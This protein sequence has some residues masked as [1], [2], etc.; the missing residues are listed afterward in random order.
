MQPT[1]TRPRPTF[2]FG[3]LATVLA[4]T[5]AAC[6]SSAPSD[7]FGGTTTLHLTG[8]VTGTFPPAANCVVGMSGANT[9][10]ISFKDTSGRISGTTTAVT[11]SMI[12]NV[13]VTGGSITFPVPTDT[14]S[15][16]LENTGEA[17]AYQ[18]A[19]GE[20]SLFKDSAGTLTVAS[21]GTSGSID[22]SL[23]PTSVH[24]NEANADVQISGS[25]SNCPQKPT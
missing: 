25:W 19:A 9:D 6:G 16:F 2:V 17:I 18:W 12:I 13:P 15:V 4:L 8:Q 11:L 21:G 5:I 7:A 20:A 22:L 23:Q 24:P 1:G 14:S 10:L 3:A